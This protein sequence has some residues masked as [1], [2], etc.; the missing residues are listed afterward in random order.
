MA[1]T[2]DAAANGQTAFG[3]TLTYSHTVSGTDRALFVAVVV[4]G[5]VAIS[6]VTYNGVAMTAVETGSTTY[7]LFALAAPATGANDVVV[8]AASAEVIVA[9]SA[10][11]NGVDQVTPY[12]GVQASAT[13]DGSPSVTVTSATDNLVVGMSG[14]GDSVGQSVQ[15]AGAAQTSRGS[16]EENGN[17]LI[18]SDEPGA[19]ST[20]HSYTRNGAF[21]YSQRIVAVNVIAAAVAGPTIDTQPVADVGLINGDPARRTTVYTATA[22]GTNVQAPTWREDATPISDGGIYDIVTTGAGTG[23]CTSTLTITRTVKTGTPFD[24]AANFVDD[25]GNTDTD[26]VTDTWYTGPVL[27][28]TSGTTNGSG[29]DTVDIVSDYPNADGEFTVVPATA[30]GV[31]KQVSLHYEAP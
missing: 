11:Y 24:I 27:S 9:V 16:L 17:Y 1:V 8:T 20:T 7:R 25:N 28:K 13:G 4:G 2:F 29:V 6:G 19:A 23:T 10:S 3:T 26:T 21:Y 31:T 22:S 15:T 18:L 14:Y 30:G 12:D 5:G